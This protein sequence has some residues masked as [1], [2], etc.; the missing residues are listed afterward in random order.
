MVSNLSR[1]VA[2]VFGRELGV[3]D[4]FG[5]LLE[6]LNSRSRFEYDQYGRLSRSGNTVAYDSAGNQVDARVYDEVRLYDSAGNLVVN[7]NPGRGTL[8]NLTRYSYNDYGELT[9]EHSWIGADFTSIPLTDAN[10]L[11]DWVPPPFNGSYDPNWSEGETRLVYDANGDVVSWSLWSGYAGKDFTQT[12]TVTTA[13][14]GNRRIERRGNTNYSYDGANR[15]TTATSSSGITAYSY[16]ANGKVNSISVNGETVLEYIYYSNGLVRLSQAYAV[17]TDGTRVGTK[18]EEWAYDAAGNVNA[19]EASQAGAVDE[20][21]TNSYDRSNRVIRSVRVDKDNKTSTTETTYGNQ[22]SFATPIR[23]VVVDSTYTYTYETDQNGIRIFGAGSGYDD[24]ESLAILDRNGRTIKTTQ[25]NT[26]TQD[27]DTIKR[28]VYDPFGKLVFE[29][30]SETQQDFVRYFYVNGEKIATET[31]PAS[32]AKIFDAVDIDALVEPGDSGVLSHS[33]GDGDTLRALALR[34]YGSQDLWY[35][36][37]EVNGLADGSAALGSTLAIP[38]SP[39]SSYFNAESHSL[40]RTPTVNASSIPTLSATATATASESGLTDCELAG[41]IAAI[42]VVAI[43]AAVATVL[44]VG[45]AAPVAAAGIASLVG[46]ATL[47]TAAT[48]AVGVA[49]GVGVGAAIALAASALTQGI[50]VGTGLQTEFDWSQVAADALVGGLGGAAAGLGGAVNAAKAATTAV[51][52][53]NVTGQLALDIGA[54]ISNQA[55]TKTGVFGDDDYG[56]LFIGLAGLGAGL[57]AASDALGATR[58][59]KNAARIAKLAEVEELGKRSELIGKLTQMDVL[60]VFDNTPFRKELRETFTTSRTGE[61]L[62]FLQDVRKFKFFYEGADDVDSA[63]GDIAKLQAKYGVG[64]GSEINVRADYS[65]QLAVAAKAVKDGPDRVTALKTYIDK[66]SGLESQINRLIKQNQQLAVLSKRLLSELAPALEALPDATE[67]AK[68]RAKVGVNSAAEA[69]EN[70][71]LKEKLSRIKDSVSSQIADNRQQKSM[72]SGLELRARGEKPKSDINPSRSVDEDVELDDDLLDE[73]EISDVDGDRNAPNSPRLSLANVGAQLEQGAGLN[74]AERFQV[75]F[76][77]SRAVTFGEQV[78]ALAT[79]LAPSTGLTGLAYSG[80]QG[81][82]QTIDALAARKTAA[83]AG[84]V[85]N[86]SY[87]KRLLALKVGAALTPGLENFVRSSTLGDTSQN[88]Y[89]RSRG[90]AFG[91]VGRAL[92]PVIRQVGLPSISSLSGNSA[93]VRYNDRLS[94]IV[95]EAIENNQ[96]KGDGF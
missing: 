52:I 7:Y 69:L 15:L 35:V 76:A 60:D 84:S 73:Y 23:E 11:L 51:K 12:A 29:A 13:Y 41:V 16:Y 32:G 47:S 1:R 10:S 55:I 87:K 9:S 14:D 72:K 4:A 39:G 34:Y 96:K 74:R 86:V 58:K 27:L 48:V 31:V 89:A 57:G 49:V 77:Q 90:G 83:K 54:E 43:V 85:A 2:D 81:L 20:L 82:S 59:A 92:N 64:G 91:A 38:P 56:F 68:L 61:N 24:G 3:Y 22:S 75:R 21:V 17:T 44:T 18:R 40:A 19:Y 50:L 78:S 37:A 8:S 36:I 70:R 30:G 66:L 67:L 88:T 53:A 5:R 71:S 6:D 42:V 63:I 25:R 26:I 45:A 95:R 94:I 62:E 65:T 93:Q 80:L 79:G 28:Y 33:V 46:V